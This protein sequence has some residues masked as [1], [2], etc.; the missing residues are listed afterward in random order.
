MKELT[1]RQGEVLAFCKAFTAKEQRFPSFATIAEALKV[2][3]NCANGHLARM[4]KKGYIEKRGRHWVFADSATIQ[5]RAIEL[6]RRTLAEELWVSETT[7]EGIQQLLK[8]VDD[9]TQ[10]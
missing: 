8:E 6:L 3:P 7:I 1:G 2:T 9:E 5:G 4:A 10:A